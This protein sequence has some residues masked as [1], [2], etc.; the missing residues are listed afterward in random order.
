VLR[1]FAACTGCTASAQLA[2]TNVTFSFSLQVENAEYVSVADGM[3]YTYVTLA[4]HVEE[5]RKELA[6][7]PF[8]KLA[9]PEY[10]DLVVIKALANAAIRKGEHI[11]L[12]VD[13][14]YT[15]AM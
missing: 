10:D 12:R 15:D 5:L 4:P 1:Y 8:L 14:T 6:D 2:G 11:L 3:V 9:G 7:V 13:H